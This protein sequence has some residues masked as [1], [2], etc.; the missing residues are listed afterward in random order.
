[1]DMGQKVKMRNKNVPSETV[2]RNAYR[3]AQV[4]IGELKS[5]ID[6]LKYMLSQ[7][8][9][10]IVEFKKWQ[11]NAMQKGIEFL[12][13]EADKY[14]YCFPQREEVQAAFDFL[15]KREAFLKRIQRLENAYEKANQAAQIYAKIKE[16]K[17]EVQKGNELLREKLRTS[18]EEEES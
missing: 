2:W 17:A 8:E 18:R 4:E 3:N 10:A 1:M 12:M 5:E 11:K 7:K 13:S 6:E 16:A 9:K 14:A 15:K